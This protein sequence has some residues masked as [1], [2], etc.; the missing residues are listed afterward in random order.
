MHSVG[1]QPLRQAD[2]IID[3]ECH[4]GVRADPLQWFGQPR[5]LM[6]IHALH[7]KL[8][9]RDRPSGQSRA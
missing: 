9:R 1:V 5:Q 8:E 7:P 3:D 4:V 6:L 2:T